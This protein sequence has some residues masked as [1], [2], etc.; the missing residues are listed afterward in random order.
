M[1]RIT[2]PFNGFFIATR[3][4]HGHGNEAGWQALAKI[5]RGRPDNF[6]DAFCCASVAPAQAFETAQ[7]ALADAEGRARA[8]T[9]TLAAFAFAPA[10][11]Q[12][13]PA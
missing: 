13:T 3:V 8:Q 4:T 10:Q 12:A 9:G 7:E 11:Q 2:G 1:E 5:C 6:R